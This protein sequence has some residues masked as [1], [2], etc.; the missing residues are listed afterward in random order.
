MRLRRTAA[1]AIPALIAAALAAPSPAA[2]QAGGDTLVSVGSDGKLFSQNKQ[3][4]P[5]VAVDPANPNVVAAGAN[6]NIDE[7]EC[8]AGDDTTC[9][10]TEGIGVSG[11]YFSLDSGAS[12]VQPTYTG[13]T[14]R[15]CTGDA[16]CE[17]RVGPIGTL[18]WY[19]E[20]HMSSDGDPALAFGPVPDDTGAFSWDNG[21]R[22]YYANLTANF[23]GEVGFKGEEAITASRTD[24]AAAAAAGDKAAWSPPV[25]A[26]RQASATFSDKEQI[27]ADNAASSQFFGNVYLCFARFQGSGAAPMMVLTSRDGGD[28]WQ[29]KQVS[30]AAAVPPSMWGQSGC[31]V[32]TDSE[33]TVYVFYEQFQSPFTF[34]SPIG[35]HMVVRSFDGG[36]SWTRPRA[37]GT[38]HDPCPLLQYD[39][40][41][42]RCVMD[43]IAG[44]RADLTGSPNVTIA[45][46]A[47]SGDGA[48]DLIVR[49]WIDAQTTNAEHVLVST[50]TDGIAW[51]DPAR[52]ERP[53]DRGYYTA[54]ALSPDGS[55]LYLVYNAFTTPLR[56]DTTSARGLVGV[57]MHADVGS[58]GAISN[59]QTLNV[60]ATG[61]PRASS[62]NNLVME[63]LGD[64]VYAAATNDYGV[65]VWNDVRDGA[66]C[67]AIQA[68]RAQVQETLDI[69][70]DRVNVEASCPAGFGDSSI[71]GGSYADPT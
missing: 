36:V 24:D 57:V 29:S 3:N 20:N 27:W 66:V 4:E 31:A 25:V 33:G 63:F 46:G 22:L 8:S 10:F 53:G 14:A 49:N 69:T 38:T 51:T 45:N 42:R 37:I 58:G 44:A 56:N 47:P 39:G 15:H 59:W 5:A 2:A 6:D 18:P 30:R 54:P 13:W 32:R 26:S 34:P 23:P 61:D 43:G 50:S 11:I 60:G 17:P 9:P 48:T 62:Q 7:E 64:Y 68:W 40:A 12:W 55:D 67:P 1:L 28:T 71:Y 70:Q 35:T 41:T 65:A 52:V 19:Y 21:S 16:E